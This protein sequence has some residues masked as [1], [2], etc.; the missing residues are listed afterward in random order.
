ML[1][2]GAVAL[3]VMS[4]LMLIFSEWTVAGIQT[5]IGRTSDTALSHYFSRILST[6]LSL[7]KPTW[8]ECE[9]G[10]G[11][12][13]LTVF[14]TPVM[15]RRWSESISGFNLIGYCVSQRPRKHY[16]PCRGYFSLFTV[17]ILSFPVTISIYTV[18]S[19]IL[20]GWRGKEEDDRP[21][22]N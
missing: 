15:F 22:I 20:L 8:S 5:R 2:F 21:L 6:V 13:K 11:D 12:V 4:L 10:P 16:K 18:H 3:D 7:K 9:I 19:Y 14:D 1:L 17:E